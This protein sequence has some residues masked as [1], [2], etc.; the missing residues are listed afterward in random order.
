MNTNVDSAPITAPRAKAQKTGTSTKV[1]EPQAT[2]HKSRKGKS[3]TPEQKT[4]KQDLVVAM[5]RRK[6]GATVA[7]IMKVTGWQKHSVHGFF[8]GV[9]RKKLQFNLVRSGEGE[10]ATY[11]IVADKAQ[12]PATRSAKRVA[13]EKSTKRPQTRASKRTR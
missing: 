8:A 1:N 2:G 11:R 4:S 5:L 12:S 6:E 13:A 9:V 7:V 3:K 10:Q